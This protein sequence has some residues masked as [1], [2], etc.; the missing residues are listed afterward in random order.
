MRPT[1]GAARTWRGALIAH[2][3]AKVSALLG[4]M[5]DARLQSHIPPCPVRLSQKGCLAEVF[6]K[7][8]RPLK[9]PKPLPAKPTMPPKP[10][11][12]NIRPPPTPPPKPTPPAIKPPPNPPKPIAPPRP[13][14]R[15]KPPPKPPP[16]PKPPPKP[17]PPQ[18]TMPSAVNKAQGA[19][20]ESEREG[21]PRKG[22]KPAKPV[23]AVSGPKLFSIGV[24]VGGG[25]PPRRPPL[26]KKAPRFMV[27]S[28]VL[29]LKPPNPPTAPPL[30]PA[31]PPLKP[32]PPP[33]PLPEMTGT[34]MVGSP[35]V[36]R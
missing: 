25:K 13:P 9:P 17:S 7:P 5:C 31:N 1:E 30:K 35:G 15:P 28:C 32:P 23:K 34:T 16:R 29:K 21:K 3:E 22:G 8:L 4:G 19:P 6:H 11:P 10:K 24:I 12:P 20:V 36:P 2:P 18:P 14:P 33:T 26:G 27:T